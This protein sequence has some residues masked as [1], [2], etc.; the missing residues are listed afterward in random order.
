MLS[1]VRAPLGSFFGLNLSANAKMA[2]QLE[3]LPKKMPYLVEC[4][5]TG[6]YGGELQHNLIDHRTGD[7]A[8]G[9][10]IVNQN[11]EG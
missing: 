7:T 5:A 8:T 9:V 11:A 6:F 4:L 2:E 10:D 1:A 3:S